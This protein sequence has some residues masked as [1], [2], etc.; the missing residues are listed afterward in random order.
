MLVTLKFFLYC[1]ISECVKSFDVEIE[2]PVNYH[3]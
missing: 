2:S 3:F 1:F